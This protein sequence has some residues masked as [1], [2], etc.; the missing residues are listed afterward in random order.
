MHL[1]AHPLLAA[2][3]KQGRDFIRLL[4]ACDQ[5][6]RYRQRFAAIDRGIDLFQDVDAVMACCSELQDAILDLRPL[7]SRCR[8]AQ[9]LA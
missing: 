3:G 4:D 1:H 9:T 2:W 7:P 8:A 6:D 5:P